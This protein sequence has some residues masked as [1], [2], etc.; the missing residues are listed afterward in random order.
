MQRYTRICA[1]GNCRNKQVIKHFRV[2]TVLYL[3]AF[4]HIIT[5]Q[6]A[7]LP[8]PCPYSQFSTIAAATITTGPFNARC[9]K[10]SATIVTAHRIK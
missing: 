10:K 1:P 4:H 2:I 5:L 7:D 9:K 3:Q 6:Q 8:Y